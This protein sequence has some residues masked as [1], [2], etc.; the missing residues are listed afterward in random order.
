VE[1]SAAPSL[2]EALDRERAAA[3]ARVQSLSADLEGIMADTVEAN[4]GLPPR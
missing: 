1:D 3:V 2:R 4:M